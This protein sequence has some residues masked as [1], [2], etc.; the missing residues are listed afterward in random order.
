MKLADVVGTVTLSRSHPALAG[1]TWK[2]VVPLGAAALRPSEDAG[3]EPGGRG[4]P[5]AA[6]DALGAGVGSRVALA[7]GPEAAAPWKPRVVPLDASV[8]A[9]IDD[10]DL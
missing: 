7:E 4:E 6:A 9:L 8:A 10:V 5:L 3:G 1:L 2:L